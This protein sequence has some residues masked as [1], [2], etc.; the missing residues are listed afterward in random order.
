MELCFWRA[1]T[2]SR[3][4]EFDGLFDAH[5][6]AFREQRSDIN[7]ASSRFRADRQ[8]YAKL[9]KLTPIALT[10]LINVLEVFVA[11]VVGQLDLLDVPAFA[12]E[13]ERERESEWRKKKQ[14]DVRLSRLSASRVTP[15][16]R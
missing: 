4:I 14:D 10:R 1:S 16:A 8:D 12:T 11:G 2:D 7:N 15:V 9:A 3:R 6:R 13:R 5:L